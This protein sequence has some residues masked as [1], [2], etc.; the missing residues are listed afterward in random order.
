MNKKKILITGFPHTG[1]SILKSKLGESANVHE[2][3]TEGDVINSNH[4]YD[5]GTKEFVLT[6][7]PVIPINIRANDVNLIR[8]EN[9]TYKD[10]I[11]IFVTRNPYYV[12]TSIIKSGGNPLAVYEPFSKDDP[13]RVEHYL[14]SLKIMKD[15]KEKNIPNT[16]VIRYEDFFD[17]DGKAIKDIMDDI[18]LIYSNDIFEK[19]TKDYTI[20]QGINYKDID[21]SKITYE[22]NKLAYR[23]WQI[24]QPFE[25]MN[26]EVNISDELSD[27]LK[28]SNI[29][30]EFGYSDPRVTG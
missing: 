6:K 29:I 15:V 17:N 2:L 27:I 24:N 1:T 9:S 22:S 30:Q 8:A 23:I 26:L 4:L 28:N 10:Y 19:R 18:G 5:A 11:L 21:V 13:I 7:S 12:F 3:L 16:Y 20:A 14:A 25:N